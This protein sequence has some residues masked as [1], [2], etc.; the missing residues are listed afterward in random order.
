MEGYRRPGPFCNTVDGFDLGTLELCQSPI[1]GPLCSI[2]LGSAM[3]EAI[4]MGN[5]TQSK[6]A[7]NKPRKH[8]H[9]LLKPSAKVMAI[10]NTE[11]A[12]KINFDK[13]ADFEGGQQL[14]GYIPDHTLGVKH[15]DDKVAG[16][17]GVTIATGFDIGQWSISDLSQK[18]SLSMALVKKYERF[19]NK[20]KQA[21]IDELEKSGGLFVEKIEADETDMRIQRFHLIAAMARWDDDPKPFEKFIEL[22]SAQQTVILSRT[23]HQGIGMPDTSVAQDFYSAAQKGDWITAEKALR[24]Y[25][26]QPNGYKTRVHQEAD[27]LA[28]DL[29]QNQ[30]AQSAALKVPS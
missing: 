22:T 3:A 4:L 13:L 29:K 30:N 15:D 2:H 27:L 7:K 23:Y 26:V 16:K 18:L 19:C 21:A 11:L 12:T 20:Q 17:S 1:P 9:V 14:Q 25:N 8:H 6:V 28:N 10:V 24:N 5:H